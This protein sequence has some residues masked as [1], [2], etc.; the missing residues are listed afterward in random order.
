MEIIGKITAVAPV[1]RGVSQRGP[2]ARATIVV[3]YES[4]QYPRSV[5]L[6]NS[7]DAENF[8]QLRVGQTGK[9][10]IDMKAREYNGKYYTDINCWKWDVQGATQP[11]P[12]SAPQPAG[13]FPF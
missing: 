7:K 8:A 2:W 1:E 4:G 11:A 12:Q 6:Q 9:F 3:E 13:D 10:Y 5:A